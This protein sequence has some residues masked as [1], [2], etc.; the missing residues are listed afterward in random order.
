MARRRSSTPQGSQFTSTAF[1]GVLVAAGIATAGLKTKKCGNPA[2]AAISTLDDGG[3][4][5]RADGRS[6]RQCVPKEAAIK[7][8]AYAGY[9]R[10]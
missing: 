4:S 8:L 3:G 2:R 7:P 9:S 5:V 10:P 1:T 6:C